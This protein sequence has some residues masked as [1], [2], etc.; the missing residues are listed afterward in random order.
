MAESKG[1][2]VAGVFSS[3]E[4]PRQR[5]GR[6][7]RLGDVIMIAI[8]AVICGADGW[9]EV[10]EFG[11]AKESWLRQRLELANG[12]P[13]HDTFARVFGALDAAGFEQCFRQWVRAVNDLSPGQVV[14]IDG[15]TVRR[16]H[17]RSRGQA[18]LHLVSAW[19]AEN[20]LVL[21]QVAVR[22]KSNEITAIPALLD[23][24]LLAG[25]VVTID[26]M[27]CQHEIAKRI[28]SAGGDYVLAVKD[29]QPKLSQ[30]V[31]WLFSHVDH[32]DYPRLLHDQHQ[33]TEK[34]H[35]RIE[36]RLVQTITDPMR[37]RSLDPD[38]R[39]PLLQDQATLLL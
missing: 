23:L 10:E 7:H 2:G 34:N 9:V 33:S 16:S 20:R 26:A 21:G 32:P 25:T 36:T 1:G 18:A 27:G 22:D 31:R 35:G 19:A 28:T 30:E 24:L 4:D 11:K 37:L 38:G 39:W 15:K 6:R 12:I 8:A 5:R 17:D 3:L 29:N 14:A 13:S